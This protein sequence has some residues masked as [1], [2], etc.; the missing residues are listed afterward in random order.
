MKRSM[1]LMAR[2]GLYVFTTID[3]N[4]TCRAL[5]IDLPCYS[6]LQ[7]IVSV[8]TIINVNVNQMFI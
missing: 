4:Q 8:I 1:G 3:I 5:V 7:T 2:E 6:A